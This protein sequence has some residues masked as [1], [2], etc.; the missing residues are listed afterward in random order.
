ML[1]EHAVRSWSVLT[2][3]SPATCMGYLLAFLFLWRT[4]VMLKM[5]YN[6]PRDMPM[7]RQSSFLATCIFN[8]RFITS[9]PP[10]IFEKYHELKKST[11]AMPALT[12]YQ[13]LACSSSDIQATCEAPE[14]VLS[15]HEAM[16]DRLKHK[17]TMF[18][19][20]H[21]DVDP[22]NAVAG[23]T[24]KVLLRTH[25]QQLRNVIENGVK[26][27]FWAGTNGLRESPDGWLNV[28]LFAL[29]RQ[30]T[31]RVNSLVFL[32]P[33]LANSPHFM[34]S[35]VRYSNDAII[36]AEICRQLPSIFTPVIAP[37]IMRLTGSMHKV[38]ASIRTL[39]QTR[40]T[41]M[42]NK[43]ADSTKR[44]DCVQWIIES[45]S[46]PAQRTLDRLVQQ[47][48]ALFFASS[49]QMPMALAYAIHSLCI[50]DKYIEL[51]RS[52]IAAAYGSGEENPLRH[53]HLL[54]AFL[55]ESARLNPLDALSVQRKVL[56]PFKL[57][58]G[59]IIPPG[60]LIAVP[61]QALLMDADIYPAPYHFD[62]YR[63]FPEHR[64]AKHEDVNTRYT[65]VSITYP[66]WGSP[67]KPCPGRWYVSDTLMLALIHLLTEYD[68][69][70]AD[71]SAS[72]SFFWTT[73]MVPRLSTRIL[74]KK[75]NSKNPDS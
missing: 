43:P 11:F 57:P 5:H 61:Q 45:S 26:A 72:R 51:L 32:G 10:F 69:K 6:R 22:H 23:R 20:E 60:N 8:L 71:K 47:I 9:A 52:E 58:D 66:F 15:F 1:K 41:E 37:V 13:V 33:E 50:H 64:R 56:H 65:D 38:A 49:H 4:F 63:H 28:P 59:G 30:I 35:A 67:R 27:G 55:R 74:L 19:F 46:T 12:E 75:R 68:F 24:L 70:I 48:G 44:L 36:A 42:D 16:T 17:Y 53:M 2:S 62:P 25:L 21:N 18:G 14:E 3:T 73:A 29:S 31:E 39:V 34:K 54:N 40:L 7:K